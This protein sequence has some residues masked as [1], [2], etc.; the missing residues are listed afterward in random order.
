MSESGGFFQIL[1]HDNYEQR[2]GVQSD[3]FY[4]SPILF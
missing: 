3:F 1:R 2:N 4:S